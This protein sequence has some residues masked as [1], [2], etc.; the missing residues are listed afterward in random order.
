MITLD[1]S[2]SEAVDY[3]VNS[4][5]AIIAGGAGVGKTTVIKNVCERLEENGVDLLLCAFAGKAAARMKEATNRESST[6]HRMLGHNGR[7][8]TVDSLKGRT[9]I[10]DEASMVNSELMADVIS[11]EPDKLI[12]VGDPAQLAPVG[13]GQ[14]FHDTINCKPDVVKHLTKCYRNS[15]AV[16]KA[17]TAIRNGQMPLTT[18]QSDNEQWD[19]VNVP[20]EDAAHSLIL[21]WVRDNQDFI[22]FDQDII[23]VPR[24]GDIDKPCTVKG[25]NKAIVDIVN[26]RED[27]EKWKVGDRVI[28]TKNFAEHDVWNGTT[29]KIHSIDCDGAIWVETDLPTKDGTRTKTL[30]KKDMA[31][32][33][34][35]AYALTVHKSQGSQ[36]RKV[37]FCCLQRDSRWLNRSLIYTAVT[38]TKEQCIVV[39]SM[40]ALQRGIEN[41]NH[42][43]TVLQ[44]LSKDVKND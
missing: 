31:Q 11:R 8:Y 14:P 18:D 41:E 20:G 5:F 7:E 33:L 10:M 44:E 15:E 32:K 43:T 28:N 3:A 36:Y 1:P 42:K 38:R 26:P 16:F 35:L 27:D 23:L 25:L 24:N 40:G 2:Q 9:V 37:I 12:L 30:F 17:A 39:G 21:S 13:V 22:D 34:E 19:I 4:T 29:G 6:I